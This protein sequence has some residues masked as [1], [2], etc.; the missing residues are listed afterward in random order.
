MHLSG[1]GASLTAILFSDLHGRVAGSNPA[2][3]LGLISLI[4]ENAKMGS[5]SRK[6]GTI[7]KNEVRNMLF[8]KLLKMESQWT[9]TLNGADAKV[10]TNKALLDMFGTLPAMRNRSELEITRMF[11]CAFAKDPLGAVRCLFYT[12]DIRGGQG[13]RDIFRLL[14]QHLARKHP[15]AVLKN[16]SLIPE[17]GRFDDLYCLIG[18]PVETEMWTLMKSQLE[19]DLAAMERGEPVSLLA[20]WLKKAN[21]SNE[22]TKQLGIYTAQKLGYSVYNYK[23]ISSRLRKYQ[24]VVEISMSA[25]RWQSIVYPQVPSR[26]MM[27]Y[28]KAYMR[29]DTFRFQKYLNAVSQGTAQIHS[30]TLYPYDIV[31]R[32]MQNADPVLE[33]QW[34]ALP[35]YIQNGDNILV[36]ADVSGSMYG[37]P[38]ASAIALAIYFAER[39]QGAYHNLFMTFSEHPQIQELRGNTLREKVQLLRQAAWGMSTNFQAAMELILKLAVEN[40][41]TQEELPKALVVVTDMEFNRA[42]HSVQRETFTQRIQREF[43]QYGYTAPTLVFWNV[44]SRQDVFHSDS[45]DTGVVLVAGQSASTFQ[46]IIRCLNGEAPL[47]PT[48][49]MYQ[50]LNSPRYQP[51]QV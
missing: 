16:L 38:M 22:K 20:K 36:M 37:R 23:R 40:H 5:G 45:T 35:N 33:Q 47:T 11:D 8:S 21:S 14:L 46:N 26:A 9:R 10:T 29:H 27:N 50:V 1:N 44:N 18:T 30:G 17:Y 13:E 51:V 31:E 43:A 19:K 2:S 15:Q 42:D 7:T 39:C 28:R 12:R 6:D 25:K 41:C 4:R 48:D 32:V 24:N 49:F 3:V 34:L